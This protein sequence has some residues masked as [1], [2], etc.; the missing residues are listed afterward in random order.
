MATIAVMVGGA[1][2]NA[3]AFTGGNYLMHVLSGSDKAEAEKNRHDLAE[4]AFDHANEK[5]QRERTKLLDWIDQQE[6][7]KEKAD[8][9][10]SVT[11]ASLQR[12]ADAHPESPQ[13][14]KPDF[15]DFYTPSKEQQSS[16][17]LFV[18]GGGAVVG[19]AAAYF[20]L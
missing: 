19:L 4:E 10:F 18:G 6:K 8:R 15:S 12:Y 7:A 17:L 3:A 16:E 1:I 2:L 11:D 20:L 9:D 5:Y 14:K 13:L